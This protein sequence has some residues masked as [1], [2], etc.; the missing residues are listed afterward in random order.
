MD[1]TTLDTYK[2]EEREKSKKLF[3]KLALLNIVHHPSEEFLKIFNFHMF[4]KPNDKA[5]FQVM[6]YLFN[7]LDPGEVKKRFYWPITDKKYESMFRTATVSFIN[8]LIE[9]HKIKWE[10]QIMKSYLVVKPGG[11]KFLGFLHDF[12]DFLIAELTKKNEKLLNVENQSIDLERIKVH[13]QTLKVYAGKYASELDMQ[14]EEVENFSVQLKKA[15][16]KLHALTGIPERILWDSSFHK[17]VNDTNVNLCKSKYNKTAEMDDFMKKLEILNTTLD[18]F[19]NTKTTTPNFKIL[20]EILPAFQQVFTEINFTENHTSNL[21]TAF[22]KIFPL[23]H[24]SHQS[25]YIQPRDMVDYENTELQRIRTETIQLE[26]ELNKFTSEYAAARGVTINCET[27]K[28]SKGE[29]QQNVLQVRFF[30][31]IAST[32][33]IT[34]QL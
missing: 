21:I 10:M 19:N 27:P 4:T 16:T 22:N 17:F 12:I 23:I 30:V 2:A 20:D 28:R 15:F 34:V 32:S 3:R 6:Y 25:I 31:C 14:R 1:K 29:G 9:K 11:M 13:S 18:D 8:H 24:Q 7:I 33:R 5:F 26:T